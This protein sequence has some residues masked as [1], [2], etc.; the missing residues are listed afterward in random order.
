MHTKSQAALEFLSTY[1]WGFLIIILSVGTLYYLGIFDFANLLPQKCV[2][3]S[4]FKCLDF[5]LQPTEVKIK[6]YNGIGEDVRVNLLQITGD[7]DPTFACS[8]VNPSPE[9]DWAH[10]TPL[11]ITF[12]SCSGNSYIRKHRAE[13]RVKLRYYAINTPSKPN[14]VINGK[15]NGKVTPS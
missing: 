10:D 14:H 2:F 13:L 9:F 11:D 5:S 1:V 6:L 8:S 3:P 12:S 15:I 7:A 4:Q